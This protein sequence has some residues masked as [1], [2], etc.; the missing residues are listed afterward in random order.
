[1]ERWIKEGI[2]GISELEIGDRLRF[3]ETSPIYTITKFARSQKWV[4]LKDEKGR[5]SRIPITALALR[6]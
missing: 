2:R 1:M 4:G 6:V 3:R 5:E